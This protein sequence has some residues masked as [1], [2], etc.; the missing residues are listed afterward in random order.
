MLS[1]SHIELVVIL[2]T[3][4]VH[5]EDPRVLFVPERSSFMSFELV[6]LS[7]E[8]SMRLR[9]LVGIFTNKFLMISELPAE[10]SVVMTPLNGGLLIVMLRRIPQHFL[11]Y[12]VE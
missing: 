6:R 4:G 8:L 7:R 12:G 11:S 2:S 5:R 3:F 9:S 1:L 10:A